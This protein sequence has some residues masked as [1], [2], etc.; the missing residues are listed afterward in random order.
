MNTWISVPSLPSGHRLLVGGGGSPLGVG[1]VSDKR[2]LAN[3]DHTHKVTMDRAASFPA[4]RREDPSWHFSETGV[5]G[6]DRIMRLI[7][8]PCF[9]RRDTVIRPNKMGMFLALEMAN[10]QNRRGGRM[11]S[12]G[13]ESCSKMPS[14]DVSA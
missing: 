14:I 7:A 2:A 5:V 6:R 4:L 11:D 13:L 3:T 8:I 1:R 9:L 10:V 12:L